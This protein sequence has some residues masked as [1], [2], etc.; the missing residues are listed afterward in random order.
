MVLGCIHLTVAHAWNAVRMIN[1]T[2]AIAQFG[3]VAMT[4]TMFFVAKFLF[5]GNP[6]P[7]WFMPVSVCGLLA[8]LVFMT[9][10]RNLKQEW[11]NHAMLPLSL[12]STFGDVLSYLRLF[13]LGIAT[14]EVANA[15]NTM[16]AKMGAGGIM[17]GLAAAFILFVGHTLN[18][19]LSALS[20]LVHGIRLNALEFSMHLGLEWS[21]FP[22]NPFAA[23]KE[24]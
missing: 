2:R 21:G 23:R 7:L 12:M 15:F 14:L 10:L 6:F 1:S 4:W 24:T 18:I 5:T 8:I 22:Y 3:W 9:P 16:A 11:I 19:V 17:A 13:A 20:V